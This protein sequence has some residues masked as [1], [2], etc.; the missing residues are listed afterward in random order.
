M[1]DKGFEG[2]DKMSVEFVSS[3]RGMSDFI[4]QSTYRGPGDT[5]DAAMHR[6]ERM[7]GAPAS[8]MH[9]LR[10]RSIKDM[11]VSAYAAIARAYKAALE[12]S[13]K[14]YAAERELA[15]ARNSK[16]L[17][18]ADA[19]AGTPFASSV[20][21]IAPVLVKADAAAEGRESLPDKNREG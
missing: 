18:I 5:V 12:A 1:S 21:E 15:H 3:A 17:G 11:P 13:E 14:A 6:A 9:R 2:S 20:A 7:Y 19:L 16:L 4:L 10:Y 8:W